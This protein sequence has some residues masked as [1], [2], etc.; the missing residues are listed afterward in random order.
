M[1]CAWQGIDKPNIRR[2]IH[3]GVPPTLEA[4]YQQAG[5]AGRDGL[6]S[7]CTLLW[8]HRDFQTLEMVKGAGGRLNAG[9]WAR[10]SH[11][12]GVADVQASWRGGGRG[13]GAGGRVG[14]GCGWRGP[15][16]R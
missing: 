9:E 13:M 5:R 14:A 7:S 16:G 2:I 10:S 6:P 15:Q 4:Y 8:A 11:E 3:Y 1:R 12:R